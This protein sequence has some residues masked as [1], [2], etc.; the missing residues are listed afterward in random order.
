[1][2]HRKNRNSNKRFDPFFPYTFFYVVVAIVTVF[3][4]ISLAR[5]SSC[6][7]TSEAAA[8]FLEGLGFSQND[9][10]AYPNARGWDFF[11]VGLEAFEV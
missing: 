2:A 8:L 10:V 4:L 5:E 7:F 6:C 3:D 1:M 9:W 11:W